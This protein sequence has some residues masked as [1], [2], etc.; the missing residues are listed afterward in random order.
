MI[1]F[2]IGISLII[3]TLIIGGTQFFDKLDKIEG[4]EARL[5]RTEK[6]A[7]EMSQFSQRLSETKKLTMKKG[8]DQRARLEGALGL[9]EMGLNLQFTS[10]P[11][12]DSVETRFFFSH[13]FTI[14][15]QT[16]FFDAF[17]LVNKLEQTPGFVVNYVCIRCQNIRIESP[18]Q[19]KEPVQ[20]RGLINVH[21]PEQ[22]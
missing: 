19:G 12:P 22:V 15:G 16:S 20:I 17:N 6:R 11:E 13:K 14:S 18:E 9:R 21:N 10:S 4:A 5:E 1:H 3:L 2:S 8:N 7:Q